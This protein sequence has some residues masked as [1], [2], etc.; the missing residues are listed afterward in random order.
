[1]AITKYDPYNNSYLIQLPDGNVLRERIPLQFTNTTHIPHT[2]KEGETIQSIA[3]Q[4]YGDSGYWVIIADYNAVYN[5]FLDLEEG[6]ELLI[7]VSNGI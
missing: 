1:M 2:V 3:F 5:P 7:P 4:Y 6:L